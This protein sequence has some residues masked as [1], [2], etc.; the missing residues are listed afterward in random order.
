MAWL[1][2]LKYPRPRYIGPHMRAPFYPSAQA[3]RVDKTAQTRRA[4]VLPLP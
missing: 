2:V 3:K 1:A 4:A